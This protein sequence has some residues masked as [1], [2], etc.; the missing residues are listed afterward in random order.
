MSSP[1]RSTSPTLEGH[2]GEPNPRWCPGA[3]VRRP[4]SRFGLAETFALEN[5]KEDAL[6]W[7]R[8]PAG[9]FAIG[10]GGSSS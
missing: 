8:R 2:Y 3:R 5:A 1:G 10:R 6:K 7:Y 4:P 9:F